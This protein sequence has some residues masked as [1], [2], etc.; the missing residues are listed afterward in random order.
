MRERGG[1]EP[2]PKQT[3]EI[4]AVAERTEAGHGGGERAHGTPGTVCGAGSPPDPPA[5]PET[6][7]GATEDGT[8]RFRRRA[9]LSG[10]AGPLR[11]RGDAARRPRPRPAPEG[12]GKEKRKKNFFF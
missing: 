6:P 9:R 2:R 1:G 8:G 11:E 3:G 4:E 12:S 7:S 10:R 5:V